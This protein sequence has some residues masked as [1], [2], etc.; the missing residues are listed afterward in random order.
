MAK[1]RTYQSFPFRSFRVTVGVIALSVGVLAGCGSDSVD[2]TNAAT[3]EAVATEA[4]VVD[5][6]AETSES[7]ATEPVGVA[8]TDASSETDASA[9]TEP[10]ADET[11]PA[12]VAIDSLAADSATC[13]A[14]AKVKELNDRSGELTSEFTSQMLAGA[15]E[16]DSSKV[17]QAWEGFRVKFA[18][19]SKKVLPELKAAYAT[20]ATEQP[21]YAE[22]FK[23]LDEVTVK[24]LDVFATLSFDDLDKLEEKMTAAIP[25]DK[26]IAAGMS[27]LKIDKFSKAACGIAFAN[28]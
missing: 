1:F 24:L 18:A 7:A 23:N 3:T 27:S 16:G 13:T 14:F 11:D 22:D 8:E 10:A 28:T 26:T 2:P 25:S 17:E 9:E 19:D 5:T 12:N 4:T 6:V 15:G 21:Q 20:L